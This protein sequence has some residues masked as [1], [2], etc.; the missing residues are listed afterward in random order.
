LALRDTEKENVKQRLDET[1]LDKIFGN[2]E[3]LFR[4][5]KA[6]Y[7]ELEKRLEQWET[8]PHMGDIFKVWGPQLKPYGRYASNF[9]NAAQKIEELKA[10]NPK[11][12]K[13]FQFLEANSKE[14]NGL[15][16]RDYLIMPVQRIPRY[17]LLLQVSLHTLVSGVLFS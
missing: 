4:L 5:N 9:E 17:S 8:H 6:L 2:V 7:E 13:L 12:L 15:V 3:Q 10:K 16:L 11:F 1:D 14:Y